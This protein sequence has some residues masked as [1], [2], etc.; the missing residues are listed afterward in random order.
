[1]YFKYLQGL[2]GGRE[3]EKRKEGKKE[4]RKE[5]LFLSHAVKVIAGI[6]HIS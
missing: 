5:D 4:E 1:M 6:C 3:E 2:E